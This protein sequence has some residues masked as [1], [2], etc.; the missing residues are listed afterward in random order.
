MEGTNNSLVE[1]FKDDRNR[2]HGFRIAG[3]LYV[4]ALAF[5]CNQYRDCIAHICFTAGW[6]I[7]FC[8][9]RMMSSFS[10]LSD[11]RHIIGEILLIGGLGAKFFFLSQK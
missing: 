9:K 3:L 11:V 6:W 2:I 7:A 1:F 5:D 8:D 4:V 10:Q